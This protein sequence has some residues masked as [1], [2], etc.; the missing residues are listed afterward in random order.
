MNRIETDVQIGTLLLYE[1]CAK[2]EEYRKSK[3]GSF[4]KEL[5]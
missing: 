3:R 1:F 4:K 2:D 5:T